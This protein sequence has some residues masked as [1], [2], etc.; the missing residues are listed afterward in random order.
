LLSVALYIYRSTLSK[1]RIEK[2]RY[3]N[4]PRENRAGFSC[5]AGKVEDELHLFINCP[6]YAHL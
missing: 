2:G 3:Y 4:I 1:F 5:K 6:S